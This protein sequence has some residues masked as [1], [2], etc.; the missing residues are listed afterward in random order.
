MRFTTL[1]LLFAGASAVPQ[2]SSLSGL[3]Q[4]LVLVLE[5]PAPVASGNGIVSVAD[6]LIDSARAVT[7]HAEAVCKSYLSLSL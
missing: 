3:I 2:Q 6:T 4:K 7:I 1:A 5:P